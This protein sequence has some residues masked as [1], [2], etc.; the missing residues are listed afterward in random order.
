MDTTQQMNYSS[1]P[2]NEPDDES[3]G[4]RSIV[5]LVS[6]ITIGSTL[7]KSIPHEPLGYWDGVSTETNIRFT[8]VALTYYGDANYGVPYAPDFKTITMPSG[9]TYTL[10][11]GRKR[12]FDRLTFDELPPGAVAIIGNEAHLYDMP[13][14]DAMP[15]VDKRYSKQ[16][17]HLTRRPGKCTFIKYHGDDNGLIPL[18]RVFTTETPTFPLYYAKKN[19]MIVYAG[20]NC[21]NI[22]NAMTIV[23]TIGRSGDKTW[24]MAVHRNRGYIQ[25]EISKPSSVTNWYTVSVGYDIDT[26]KLDLWATGLRSRGV[27]RTE[28]Y[29]ANLRE[30]YLPSLCALSGC[31]SSNVISSIF[32]LL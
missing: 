27:L 24:D 6:N 15:L 2:D 4:K 22:N 25:V 28:K 20:Y 9:K 19:G 8:T 29:S 13:D 5:S 10:E 32:G 1:S 31:L 7:V 12:V 11:H 23:N 30:P 18:E 14:T 26:G 21:I 16:V 17:S 3:N